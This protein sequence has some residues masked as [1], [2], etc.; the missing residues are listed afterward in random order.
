MN[1][2]GAR[3][4]LILR[5]VIQT[6][7]V[8]QA[9]AVVILY[10]VG[11]KLIDGYGSQSS[12]T[13]MLVLASFLGV[14][15][16]GQTFAVLL[17]GIDLSIPFVIGMAN[18]MTAQLT[19]Y[20]WP[21]IWTAL[22]IGVLAACIGAANGFISKRFS[23]HP[24]LVTLGMGSI[25]AGGLL[26]WT[27][28]QATGAAPT[29]LSSFVAINGTTLSLPVPPVIAFWA[30]LSVLILLLLR[31]TVFGNRMYATGANERAAGLALVNTTTIWTVAF[32][33]SAL[34]A[35]TAGVLLAGFSGTGF[36]DIGQPYLFTSIA[37]VVI[38][39]TSLLGARGGYGGTILGA[40]IL[41]EV[42]TILV[43]QNF[44]A[45]AQ[46]AILG[47]VILLVVATYGRE[48]QLRYRV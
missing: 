27:G 47:A 3:S 46:Q 23:I 1:A 37:A 14:A 32:A 8:P 34:L 10:I 15:A 25:V 22:F 9:A 12:I 2:F 42:T 36:P 40:L 43:G 16:A 38:G 48:V 31:A 20:G 11:S 4:V 24:L 26:V 18:V 29:W 44:S 17:G 21:F 41:T 39:G 35:A 7:L 33:C 45:A 5:R 28:G 30:V 19:G 6:P 13:S